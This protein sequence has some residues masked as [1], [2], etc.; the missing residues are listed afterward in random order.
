[1]EV[2]HLFPFL[3]FECFNKN[4]NYKI[5]FTFTNSLESFINNNEDKSRVCELNF[6]E[7]CFFRFVFFKL[8]ALVGNGVKLK[9]FLYTLQFHNGTIR[10]VITKFRTKFTSLDIKPLFSMRTMR[11]EENIEAVV[12]SVND[13]REM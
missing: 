8:A 10:A 11:I 4:F 6:S 2:V 9:S 1:M 5:A 3:S 13:D 7:G 12:F